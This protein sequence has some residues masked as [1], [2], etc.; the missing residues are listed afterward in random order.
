[1]VVNVSRRFYWAPGW[2]GPGR[3]GGWGVRCPGEQLIDGGTAASGASHAD[4][5]IEVTSLGF[6]PFFSSSS[7]SSGCTK[8]EGVWEV[9]RRRIRKVSSA[10]VSRC[11][12][13]AVQSTESQHKSRF[14]YSL[15]RQTVN[16]MKCYC[17]YP[18]DYDQNGLKWFSIEF[19]I[20]WRFFQSFP[21]FWPAK[22][23]FKIWKNSK[24]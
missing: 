5:S 22:I 6:S 11:V 1:M 7:F 14:V 3:G 15:N 20:F 9:R 8:K 2:V 19:Y 17:L 12:M 21:S 24:I 16:K 18:R 23:F 4:E 13:T 10:E